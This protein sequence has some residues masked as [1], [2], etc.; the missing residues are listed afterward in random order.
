MSL[1]FHCLYCCQ[2]GINQLDTIRV[3]IS[4]QHS[5]V[6][7]KICLFLY[8]SELTIESVVFKCLRAEYSFVFHVLVLGDCTC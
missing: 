8:A 3:P 5:V 4:T 1:S 6:I 7:L 2:Y